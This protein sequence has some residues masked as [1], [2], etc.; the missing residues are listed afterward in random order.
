MGWAT[1]RD[2]F[3]AHVSTP[4]AA[5]LPDVKVRAH[6]RSRRCG[7]R[8][9]T[10]AAPTWANLHAHVVKEELRTLLT[11]SG[12]HPERHL[13]HRALHRFH[14]SAAASGA[15][16]IHRLAATITT[17]SPAI[18]AAILTGHTNPRSQGYNRLVK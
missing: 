7:I 8:G 14:A 12:T 11:L 1:V 9:S 4:L 5:P 3:I 16:Q 15:V 2:A 10:P 6:R 13:L 18:E 17:W